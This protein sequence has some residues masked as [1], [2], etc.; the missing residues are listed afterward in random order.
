MVTNDDHAMKV[1]VKY[2][3]SLKPGETK[4]LQKGTP[5]R[6]IT[7]TRTYYNV[8]V[9]NPD[10]PIRTVDTSKGDNGHQLITKE[11]TPSVPEIIAIGPQT[12]TINYVNTEGQPIDDN[13]QPIV[14]TATASPVETNQDGD[15]IFNADG[16][17]TANTI[18]Y[19][20]APDLAKAEAA[21]YPTIV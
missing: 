7:V 21:G 3:D 10:D 13:N 17:P 12:A 4:V 14:G 19:N 11:V 6:T 1:I 20:Q 16:I 18:N 2:D 15:V 8:N 9:S 5:G